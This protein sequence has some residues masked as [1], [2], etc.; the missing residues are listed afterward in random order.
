MKIQTKHLAPYLPYRLN[1][2]LQGKKLELTGLESPYKTNDN[3]Y[4][5]GVVREINGTY[6]Q[7]RS[8]CLTDK[9]VDL[10]KP[11]FRPMSDCLKFITDHKGRKFCPAEALWSVDS[12]DIDRWNTF[13]FI[14]PYWHDCIKVGVNSHDW[15]TVKFLFEWHFDVFGLI[16]AGLAI[17]INT[18]PHD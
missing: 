11:I 5:N 9:N 12:V 4:V 14:P 13:G 3:Y 16:P 6:K 2:L 10:C 17:D 15:N 8:M 1:I 7:S 18:I